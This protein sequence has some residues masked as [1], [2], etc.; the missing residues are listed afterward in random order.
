MG[1]TEIRS[2]EIRIQGL[3]DGFLRQRPAS[4][5]GP[6]LDEDR[7][8][9][10]VEGSLNEREAGPVVSHLT[11]CSFCLHVTSDLIRLDTAFADQPETEAARET[12][13]SR[14]SEVLDGLF[15]RIFG[16]ADGA[17]FAHEDRPEQT[18]ESEDSEPEESKTP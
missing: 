15:S 6:H 8:T 1:N 4:A 2:D 12:A 3:I 9:A 13:P 16:S 10:F 18:S 7:L 14:I 11:D 17:V 5:D